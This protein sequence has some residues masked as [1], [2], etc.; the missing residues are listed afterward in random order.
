[1][2][3]NKILR[4]ELIK[5]AAKFPKGSDERRKILNI[6][7]AA[8]FDAEQIGEVVPG[9]IGVPGS[10]ADKPWMDD[11]FTQQEGE[12]LLDKQEEGILDDGEADEDPLKIA[13]ERPTIP[14]SASEKR[15]ALSGAERELFNGLVR[16]AHENKE[17]RKPVL[18][19]LCEQ[20]LIDCKKAQDDDAA[21]DED[22]KEG[23]KK[24]AGCEK[25]PEGPMRDNCEKKKEE[26]KKARAVV[27]Q[28]F[29]GGFE[30]CV[31]HFA[32]DPDFKP[33]DPGD[34]K[35]EA[36]RKLCAYIGRE[37]GKIKAASSKAKSA[38]EAAV[39][40][41]QAVRKA[42]QTPLVAV[43]AGKMAAAVFAAEEEKAQDE[44]D[45]EAIKEVSKKKA[46]RK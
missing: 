36:A 34:T 18:A 8:D 26:G 9:A 17:A 40:A 12:E 27:A 23:S 14:K 5:T 42:G 31:K 38:K 2:P 10:D 7:R 43:A 4:A 30:G 41:Y 22:A 37:W 21:E 13:P 15:A 33:K 25:L 19:L 24:K 32:G 11:E 44:G 6:I 35:E 45:K 16:L 39:S 1:M 46:H 20:G 3:A 28:K 29:P